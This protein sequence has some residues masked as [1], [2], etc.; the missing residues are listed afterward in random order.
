[1]DDLPCPGLVRIAV[2]G[3]AA[4]ACTDVLFCACRLYQTVTAL[5][6]LQPIRTTKVPC[7]GSVTGGNAATRLVR[8]PK[9]RRVCD[10]RMTISHFQDV[11]LR[12]VRRSSHRAWR[13]VAKDRTWPSLRTSSRWLPARSVMGDLGLHGDRKA[14]LLSLAGRACTGS[15]VANSG[16]RH[17][18]NSCRSCGWRGWSRNGR[19][20][21]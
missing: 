16:N 5:T 15:S 10:Q 2:G 17:C 1:M 20:C 19:W 18:G 7:N 3:Y 8:W 9:Q 4:T 21:W 13:T 12:V 6:F 14:E 11:R